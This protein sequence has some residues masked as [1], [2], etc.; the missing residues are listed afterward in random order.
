M[1]CKPQNL[2]HAWEYIHSPNTIL[3]QDQPHDINYKIFMH[4]HL[5]CFLFQEECVRQ[6]ENAPL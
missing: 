4:S 5:D 1:F 3:Q 6:Q 2:F